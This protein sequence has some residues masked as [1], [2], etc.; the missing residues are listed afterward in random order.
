MKGFNLTGDK[1]EFLPGEEVTVTA[2]WNLDTSPKSV[3]ARL[4]WFTRGKGA[5][6]VNVIETKRLDAPRAIDTRPVRFVLP[7]APYSFSGKLISLIWA[8]ELVAAPAGEAERF[9]LTLSPTGQEI[10]LGQPPVS[11][12][13]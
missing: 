5:E 8:I 3:E 4:F 6:D 12:A 11:P 9:E 7:E 1:K 13:P 2:S 10:V